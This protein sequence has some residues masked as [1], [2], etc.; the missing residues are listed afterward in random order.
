[1]AKQVV[2]QTKFLGIADYEKEG[3]EFTYAFGRSVD[4]RTNPRRLTLLP[5]TAKESGSVVTGLIKWFEE[6]NGVVYGYDASGHLYSRTSTP[7]WT[8][9]RTVANSS[10]NGLGYFGE[11]DYLY[12]PTDKV[13]GRYGPLGGTPSFADD[14]LGAQGGVP[15]NT[16]ALDLESGSSQYAS[17]AD[18]SSLSITGDLALEIYAK[19]ESLP[20]AGNSMVLM[21]KWDTNSD[22]RSYRFELYAVSGYF[23]DGSD[24]SLTISSNTTEAPI[25]SSASGTSGAYSLTATNASFATG[26]EILIHQTRGTGAGTWQR[27][28]IAGYT[29]G[30]ITTEDPLNYDYA[31]SGANC[32]QVRVLPQYTS[33]TIN[34]GI[35]YTAKAWDGTVGGILAF[36]ANSTGT[37]TGTISA[38]GKGFRGGVGSTGADG[39]TPTTGYAGEGTTGAT[40]QQQTANG[41]GGGSG[42]NNRGPYGGTASGAGGGGG[43][44]L[45]GSEGGP[46]GTVGGDPG[47]TAGNT[48]LTSMVF[49]GGGGAGGCDWPSGSGNT[50]GTGGRG[51]GIVFLTIAD[52]T[53]T[54]AIN[55][56]GAVGGNASGS[57]TNNGGAGGGGGSA[58]LKSQT[59]TLGTGLI[60]ASAGT[61]GSATGSGSVGATGGVGRIHLDYYT[62]YTGTTT[63]TLDVAQDDTLV[64]NTTYQLRLMLS[65][66][67]SNSETLAKAVSITAGTYYRFHVS[68]DASAATA[69]FFLNGVS[70]GSKTGAFTAIYNS[71]A[72]FALGC[73]FG[74]SSTA[75]N[76]FDGLL[77]DGRVWNTERTEAQFYQYLNRELAGTEAGLVAYYQLDNN[78]DDSTS[79]ANH[80]TAT[81][82]PVYSTTVAFAGPTSRL[83]LDQELNTSGN[84]YTTPVAI[85]ET[86]THRQT[87]VPT[88]DPQKSVEVLV[89][90]KGTGDWTLT[91]HDA[92]NRVMATKTLTNAQMSAGD[93]EFTFSSVWRP[94]IGQTYHFHITST[95]NDGTVTTTTSSDLETVD[96]HTYY[97]FLV[98]D[99]Y[100]PTKQIINVLAIG[101]ERYL[102]TYDGSSYD[103]HRLTLPSGHR[104]RA[105]ARWN[106]YLAIGTWQGTTVKSKDK[107]HIFL[108]NGYSKTYDFDF[109][110]PEGAIN[111]LQGN[112][113][114]LH[115]IVGHKGQHLKYI[116]G[117]KP[118][119]VRRVPKMTDATYI[120]VYPG[121]MT[122]WGALLR[123][124]W[125]GNSDNSVVERGVYTY[126][127]ITDTQ[128]ETLS[129]D[130]PIS[131]GTRTGTGVQIG[132][133]IPVNDQLLISWKD[134]VAYGVDVVDPTAAPFA[135]GTLELL[136]G[137]NSEIWR[138]KLFDVARGDFEAL[139]SGES[140]TVKYKLD[141]ASNW[142]SSDAEAT[143]GAK[144]VRLPV[145][146][147]RYKEAQVAIDF[148]TSVSTSPALL[149]LGYSFDDNKTEEDF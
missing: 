65:S 114:V 131:T 74:A 79:N 101:N 71:T 94:V 107:G 70:Q 73:S 78:A 38:E 145:L 17:R 45:A 52:L 29:A 102:A 106:E 83:D 75:E 108:W 111:A 12:Y 10:G 123:T 24:S 146:G 86:A 95:V 11:D 124:G 96:Y 63:P 82:S 85:S 77:D 27:T 14:F 104:I 80:L 58:L 72:A 57:N 141:K 135:T 120:E 62:S 60:T 20:T 89:A 30:T 99:V 47:G 127:T 8:D 110:V 134:G 98:D 53:V 142:T 49:G 84:T 34:S 4:Y 148:A 21:S 125:A 147:T 15:T 19:P 91:V 139:N 18:T 122:M 137:D 6:H 128:P 5:R 129:Y 100:H 56:N 46:N 149:G 55:V 43:N 133:V 87:F 76:F 130:Y 36:L 69:T 113:G 9:L 103:P 13:I 35:T 66:D 44:G 92:Q 116:G 118:T 144:K 105:L 138:E 132:A 88:K 115:M 119:P 136:I 28:T 109:E 32:A 23:G 59:A 25:D 51:G 67:G 64:T 31:T 42:N 1:M 3:V 7:T 50:G 40:V 33:V 39:S 93:I 140:M 54:G 112:E 81:G 61:G 16:H 121:A 126:G 90:G 97:Q 48:G 26:Q 41:N 117:N 68:W 2:S 37:V 143:A 22:E